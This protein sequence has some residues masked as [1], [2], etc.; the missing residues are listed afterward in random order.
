M[1]SNSGWTLVDTGTGCVGCHGYHQIW[2]P[3]LGAEVVCC[4]GS[5][6]V[7]VDWCVCVCVCVCGVCVCVC[8]WKGIVLT[9]NSCTVPAV[10]M[11][12]TPNARSAFSLENKC[13]YFQDSHGVVAIIIV[14]DLPCIWGQRC[15][16]NWSVCIIQLG[17]KRRDRP[18]LPSPLALSCFLHGHDPHLH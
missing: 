17:I 2:G 4:D 5:I 12:H 11:G 14:Q 9:A 15:S 7:H 6:C 16:C 18:S 10:Q 13:H 3:E 8:V 1:G